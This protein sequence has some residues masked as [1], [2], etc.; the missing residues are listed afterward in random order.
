MQGGISLHHLWWKGESKMKY[1]DFQTGTHSVEE[2]YE[3][4]KRLLADGYTYIGNRFGNPIFTNR[5]KESICILASINE[6]SGYF[7]V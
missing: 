4:V 2:H 7:A 1:I 6:Q 3:E 5:E